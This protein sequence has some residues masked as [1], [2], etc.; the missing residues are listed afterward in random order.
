M[1][2]M[3][4]IR[5]GGEEDIPVKQEDIPGNLPKPADLPPL[6]DIKQDTLQATAEDILQMADPIVP[7]LPI[8]DFTV[9]APLIMWPFDR[10]N[11]PVK[12]I[13][14]TGDITETP[15][16][17]QGRQPEPP[18][19]MLLG[20]SEDQDDTVMQQPVVGAPVF[21]LAVP[22]GGLNVPGGSKSQSENV[23]V[24]FNRGDD[25]GSDYGPDDDGDGYPDDDDD[26]HRFQ[27]S[28]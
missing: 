15:T 27:C 3:R 25:S 9:R 5:A 13:E 20:A 21:S 2:I 4:T 16:S 11:Y 14:G 7:A 12:A 10:L 24:S 22:T 17:Q 8:P 1:H 19:T 6:E 23:R 18:P 26:P 28:R